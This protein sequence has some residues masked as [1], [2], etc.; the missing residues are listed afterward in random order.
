M[1]S[2]G[3]V[4]EGLKI[5]KHRHDSWPAVRQT[6]GEKLTSSLERPN[7]DWQID[8]QFRSFLYSERSF[9]RNETQRGK[10]GYL[11]FVV[12][13]NDPFRQKLVSR[14]GKIGI[15]TMSSVATHATNSTARQ[16]PHNRKSSNS[17]TFLRDKMR[18]PRHCGQVVDPVFLLVRAVGE[19]TY[20]IQIWRD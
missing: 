11:P 6:R 19:V 9:Q 8:A 16:K 14:K 12:N 17:I 13:S 10:R 7:M 20:Y 3:S 4:R 18:T 5:E 1:V 2:T 15:V